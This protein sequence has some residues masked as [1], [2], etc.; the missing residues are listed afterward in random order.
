[1]FHSNLKHARLQYVLVE[2]S[3]PIRFASVAAVTHT[4]VQQFRTLDLRYVVRTSKQTRKGP[5]P[6]SRPHC[7]SPVVDCSALRD[8]LFVPSNVHTCCKQIN[9][10]LCPRTSRTATCVN[11]RTYSKFENIGGPCH[12]IQAAACQTSG[13]YLRQSNPCTSLYA[14]RSKA[15]HRLVGDPN[16]PCPSRAHARYAIHNLRFCQY[17]RWYIGT[18]RRDHDGAPPPRIPRYIVS[19]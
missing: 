15:Q 16:L 6:R 1:M 8:D 10:R 9:S 11:I 7:Q 3:F 12:D 17:Y 2:A 19:P 14:L 4:A 5:R 18:K 13:Q